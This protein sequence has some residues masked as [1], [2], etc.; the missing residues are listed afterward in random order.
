MSIITAYGPESVRAKL[1]NVLVTRYENVRDAYN[2]T[3]NHLVGDYQSE[4]NIDHFTSQHDLAVKTYHD[5]MFKARND[6]KMMASDL[7]ISPTFLDAVF[8]L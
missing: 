4:L 6:V 1:V 7:H 5:G 8:L 3:T 2:M